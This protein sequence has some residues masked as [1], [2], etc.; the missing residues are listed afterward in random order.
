MT[1]ILEETRPAASATP[2]IFRSRRLGH[3]NLFV[4]DI[5]R[6]TVFYRDVCGLAVQFTE[7]GLKAQFLGTGHTPHDLGM[8]ETTKGVDRYGKDG[9]LQIPGTVGREVALNHLAWEQ[10]TEADLVAGIHG[11]RAAGVDIRRLADHQIAH[12]AYLADPDGN[13]TEFYV[14]TIR[15]WRGVLHGDMDL[16]TSIWDPDA[17][18]PEREPMYDPNPRLDRV[19]E[20]PI[21]PVRLSHAVLTTSRLRELSRFY[22]EVGG[23]AVV[24]EEPDIVLLRSGGHAGPF[25]LAL[26]AAGE[27]QE[28][29]L[30]HFAFE[31]A[32]DTDMAALGDRLAGDGIAVDRV[33]QGGGKSS[34]FLRDPDGWRI[35]FLVRSDPHRAVAAG[36]APAERIF[37]I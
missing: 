22:S 8:I 21:H 30:H 31:L 10:E 15:D 6:S 16:I 35:E 18:P 12:S 25:D 34:L 33:W 14:D 19:E 3:V 37:A 2:P 11:C 17:A 24:T 23:L 9:H 4:D 1:R 20:A 26:A 7:H 29:G 13:P 27:G 5:E 32:P 28:T 36:A